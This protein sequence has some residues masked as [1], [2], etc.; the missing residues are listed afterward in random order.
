MKVTAIIV[1][2]GTG[3][4]MNSEIPKQFILIKE[5]PVLFYTIDKFE[6]CR[7][8]DEIVLV[9]GKDEVEYCKKEIVEKYNLNKVKSVVSGGKERQDSVYN[10]LKILKDT[11]IV[12]IHDGARPCVLNKDIENII[13]NTVKFEACILGT[14]VKDTIKTCNQDNE[15]SD[16]PDRNALWAANTPQAFSFNLIV[17]AYERAISE[18][19][20]STDDSMLVERLGKRIKMIE[21]SYQNIKIT[22]PEDLVIAEIFLSLNS[23][24]F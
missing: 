22:T 4:R 1:A 20:L 5:K 3:R 13:E 9:A 21:G 24:S 18:G 23:T 16:T 2:A 15:I 14:K 12:M 17:E 8:V 11:D 7:M 10:G 6:K 19:V